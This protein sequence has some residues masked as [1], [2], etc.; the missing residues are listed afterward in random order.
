MSADD[1]SAVPTIRRLEEVVVNRIAAGEVIQRP[2]NALKE[3]IENSLDAK[4]TSISVTVKDGGLKLLQIQ[5][6]GH[7]I[8]VDDMIIVCE[9]FTTSKLKTFEDLSSMSTYGFRGEALASISHVAHVR[10]TT[11]TAD[12]NCAYRASYSDG[13]IIPSIPGVPGR[14]KPHAGNNGTQITV[15]DLFYN[16]P[17]R[18]K[19]LKSPSDEYQRILDVV[20]RYAIHNEGVS[21]TCSRLGTNTTTPDV[22]TMPTGKTLDNIRQI[23]GS[24]IAGELLSLERSFPVYPL[25]MKALISN[26]NY[27]VKK[28]EFLLF[29]NHRSVESS[30]IRKAIEAV[31]LPY[32]PKGTHPWIYMSLEMDPKN[33]DV[34]VHPT[35]KEVHFV[36]EEEIIA[37]ICDAVHERLSEANESRTFLTQSLLPQANLKGLSTGASSRKQD[38]KLYEYHQVRT[39][40]RNQ[41]L[42]SFLV[43][44]PSPYAASGA[45]SYKRI[46]MEVEQDRDIE[47][48]DDQEME[49][50]TER[51]SRRQ[52]KRTAFD[53]SDDEADNPTTSRSGSLLSKIERFKGS[54][55]GTRSSSDSGGSQRE[56]TT[57][58]GRGSAPPSPTP[59]ASVLSDT[60]TQVEEPFGVVYSAARR[61]GPTAD[62][63]PTSRLK[64]IKE[65]QEE[66]EAQKDK[67]L[68]P[69]FSNLSIVGMLD[70]QR[71]LVQTNLA[72][73]MINYEVA[74]EE[75]FYQICL[76]KFEHFGYIRLSTPAPIQELVMM[77][78]EED[79]ELSEQWPEDC[80]SNEEIAETV[81]N[82]L[83]ERR[84]MLKRYFSICITDDGLLTALPMLIRQYIP[85]LGKLPDF[86]WR[87]GS[88]V[89]WENVKE[90]FRGISRQIAIFYR[91]QPNQVEEEEPL[92]MGEGDNAEKE[93]GDDGKTRRRRQ[94]TLQE[95]HDGHF[96]EMVK[97]HIFPA[98]KNNFIPPESF[99]DAKV[100]MTLAESK[101]LYSVFERC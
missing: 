65:L 48:G 38:S 33:V 93:A 17:T 73:Y 70:N 62:Q 16:M 59:S 28:S 27:N 6:N 56:P 92:Q 39:D 90:C 84:D 4:S 66:L 29:I 68:Q 8:K 79:Q 86:L 14:P 34:N 12:S 87:L 32:I 58:S 36:D 91:T 71:G 42:D 45:S 40:H 46:R 31:Y 64:A 26:A 2:A 35:K 55:L 77:A 94:K 97:R 61:D 81:K 25:K 100:V 19:G 101:Q 88:E 57:Y 60:T 99:A 76:R 63:E 67:D 85:N 74:S 3:L 50:V 13:K 49:D 52:G 23:Y 69:I 37:S 80:M 41:S 82:H 51:E 47:D 22:H 78:I 53:E 11:K 1:S 83:L 95:T 5:D 18:R 43:P 30:A 98:F 75:L 7:G 10:I 21:F 9:R 96:R 89:N 44:T 15:E 24:S 72:L 54:H 20:H